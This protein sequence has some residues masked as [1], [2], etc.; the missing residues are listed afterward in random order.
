[1]IELSKLNGTPV[2]VNPDLIRYIESAPDTVLTFTDG[3]KMMVREK[4]TDIV[5]KIVRYRRRCNPADLIK[6]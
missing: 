2:V 3:V 4:P 6:E 1:M 5:D